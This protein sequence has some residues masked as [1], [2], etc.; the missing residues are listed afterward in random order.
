M[1]KRPIRILCVED[2]RIVREGLRVI[3]DRQTDMEIVGF[4][5]SGE[6]AVLLF[7]HLEPDVT[8]MDLQLPKMNG[9]DATRF[10]RQRHAEARI[11]VLTVHQGDEDIHRALEAG[12]AT[13]LLKESLPEDLVDIVRRVH[14]GERPI[15]S[16]VQERLNERSEKPTLTPREVEVLQL[17]SLGMRNKEIA[18]SLGIGD[19]TVRTHMKKIFSKLGVQDR[20]AA[21]RVA[22]R[23][24]ILHVG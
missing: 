13:Y 21:M 5:T 12:A 22:L 24:G 15:P 8:L 1:A 18:A 7:E 4:A 10:I 3:L 14:S 11:V 23:R 2:H 6:E 19:E 9:I 16:E 20:T 17:L